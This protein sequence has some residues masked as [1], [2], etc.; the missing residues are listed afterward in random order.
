L[1]HFFP[2]CAE[3]V[4]DRAS[5]FGIGQQIDSQLDWPVSVVAQEQG[6]LFS[7]E[8]CFKKSIAIFEQAEMGRDLAFAYWDWGIHAKAKGD[9]A[10]AFEKWQLA[11]DLFLE[12]GFPIFVKQMNAVL[13]TSTDTPAPHPL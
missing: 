5:G 11:R 9:L 13:Q 1:V 10:F 7:A 6:T 2:D 8:E 12:L 4:S 3:L